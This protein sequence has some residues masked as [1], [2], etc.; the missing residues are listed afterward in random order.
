MGRVFGGAIKRNTRC[1]RETLIKRDS[2]IG[3]F[4]SILDVLIK[5]G[6]CDMRGL[7]NIARL[8]LFSP[9]HLPF[10]G[11]DSWI[12]RAN[13]VKSVRAVAPKSGRTV[14]AVN[15]AVDAFREETTL[16]NLRPAERD[17]GRAEVFDD[18][19]ETFGKHSQ[20]N[21]MVLLGHV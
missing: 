16:A 4:V 7:K 5:R 2:P 12:S 11:S 17:V 15:L 10:R 21:R 20:R 19:E 14:D 3:I 8:S 18:R 9:G 13:R 6:K 1:P